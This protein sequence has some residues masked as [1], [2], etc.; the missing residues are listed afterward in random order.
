[1][2]RG[3]TP[4]P[5]DAFDFEVDRPRLVRQTGFG[6]LD[7]SWDWETFH[8]VDDGDLI[9]PDVHIPDPEFA[10]AH[11]QTTELGDC[12]MPI[13]GPGSGGTDAGASRPPG[14]WLRVMASGDTLYVE[15]HDDVFV[16]RGAVHDA[17]AVHARFLGAKEPRDLWT[18]RL[19]LD[20]TSVDRA[21]HRHAVP[22]V[23]V[24][25]AERRFAWK[26]LLPLG[27]GEVITVEYLDTDDGT[28]RKGV[29]LP[30]RDWGPQCVTVVDV[31]PQ[32]Q[33]AARGGELHRVPVEG[34]AVNLPIL[35]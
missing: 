22:M 13:G 1:M 19:E 34:T 9:L 6:P 26:G 27:D 12:G 10:A 3:L 33:C 21:G 31:N 8:G 5:P 2:T 17:V 4:S 18:E 14:G 23:E 35:R 28:V 7:R 32:A 11:W 30:D 29:A 15:V 25:P 20:G 16:T 24:S